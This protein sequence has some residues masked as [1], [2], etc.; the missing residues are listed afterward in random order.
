MKK[1][2]VNLSLVFLSI[3]FA[4]LLA[5]VI[6]RVF[7]PQ[8]LQYKNEGIWKPDS[9][10]GWRHHENACVTANFG[11]GEIT[12]RTDENGFRINATGYEQADSSSYGV[13]V[14]G[15]SFM[16]A[17][18]VESKGTLPQLLQSRLN[19]LPEGNMRFY[20]AGVAGWNPNHYFL[21]AQRVL[22][23]TQLKIDEVLVFLYVGN[24]VVR[25]EVS[26]YGPSDR[27]NKRPFRLPGRLR[28]TEFVHGIVYPLGDYLERNSQLYMLVKKRNLRLLQGMGLTSRYFPAVFDTAH[29]GSESWEV[30]THVCKK[31]QSE[32]SERGIP[33]KFVL[34]PTT[35][36]VN[37]GIMQEYIHDFDINMDSVDLR[38]P[39]RV[40]A[41][42]FTRD[43]L[44]LYDPL[45]FFE[46]KTQNGEV[47][48]G[49]FDAHFNAEGHRAMADYLLP[50]FT[51][52]SGQD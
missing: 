32:F 46:A 30:T 44:T 26:N 11:E 24:D 14:L 31:I 25:V 22:H 2:L 6:V 27:L 48:Y 1:K 45:D 18:Q 10:L 28:R 42:L 21:E 8:S 20:N 36:Q 5:E 49:R 52:G 40:L 29:A 13:L 38:Q 7:I 39:N 23:D 35:Y 47:L 9:G 19:S 3:C 17:V 12:F 33:V 15:D 50:L 43:S 16:E 4:L 34:I 41:E 51:E 37:T